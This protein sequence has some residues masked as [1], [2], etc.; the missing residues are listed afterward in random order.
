VDH[1]DINALAKRISRLERVVAELASR[2]NV[3]IPDLIAG[4]PAGGYASDGGASG[5]G[6]GSAGTGF[7][8][9][10]SAADPEI[11]QWIQ[12]GDTI[13][14]IKRYRELTGAGLGE[15][16]QAVEEIAERNRSLG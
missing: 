11:L 10:D 8:S 5:F 6:D 16:K 1:E 7:A 13:R 15:A 3:D 14:A 4:A 9:V 2:Q 12:S